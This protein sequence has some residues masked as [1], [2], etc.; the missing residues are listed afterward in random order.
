MMIPISY[1]RVTK[2]QQRKSW[3]S[4]GLFNEDMKLRKFNQDVKHLIE[5]AWS[6]V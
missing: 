5:L 4:G 6:S 3:Q 2:G 1:Y